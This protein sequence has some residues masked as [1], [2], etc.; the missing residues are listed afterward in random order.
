MYLFLFKN[1]YYFAFFSFFKIFYLYFFISIILLF[2]CYLKLNLTVVRGSCACKLTG[3]WLDVRSR[4]YA[5]ISRQAGAVRDHNNTNSRA[6]AVMFMVRWEIMIRFTSVNSQS[7]GSVTVRFYPAT[8]LTLL[9]THALPD[10]FIY[11]YF[12]IKTDFLIIF[13]L[14]A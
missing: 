3:S 10:F 1:I 2:L 14:L 6:C 4:R 5:N 11:K 9:R 7:H 8:L 13:F 12:V